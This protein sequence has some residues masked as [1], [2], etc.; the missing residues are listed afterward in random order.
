MLRDIIDTLYQEQNVSS[1]LWFDVF[2]R[3]TLK[4]VGALFYDMPEGFL[5]R[6]ENGYRNGVT[7]KNA[8]NSTFNPPKPLA[9]DSKTVVRDSDR[10]EFERLPL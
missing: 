3:M 1:I 10:R 9:A 8:Q 5:D 6:L 7:I 4:E 2:S